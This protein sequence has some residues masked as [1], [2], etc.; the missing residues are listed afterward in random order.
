MYVGRRGPYASPSLIYLP[1]EIINFASSCSAASSSI[2]IINAVFLPLSSSTESETIIKRQPEKCQ[3]A[4]Y[5]IVGGVR[6]KIEASRLC[7]LDIDTSIVCEAAGAEISSSFNRH[8]VRPLGGMYGGISSAKRQLVRI[9]RPCQQ[10]QIN[11]IIN[12]VF[13]I[14][15]TM[16]GSVCS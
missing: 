16:I 2:N 11:I 1:R 3:S 10:G 12:I 13:I 6:V 9:S 7:A 5:H 14:G 8:H 4:A 15:E